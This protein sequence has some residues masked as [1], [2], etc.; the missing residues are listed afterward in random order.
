[1][2]IIFYSAIVEELFVNKE[3]TIEKICSTFIEESERLYHSDIKTNMTMGDIGAAHIVEKHISL[4]SKKS[5]GLNVL[6]ICNTG[7]LATCGYGTA[8]GV[9]RSLHKLNAL[10][11]VYCLETRPYN[12]GGRLTAYELLHDHIPCCLIA[13]SMV[14]FLASKTSIDVILVGGDRVAMNGDTIN[15]IGTLQL[16][17]VARHFGIPVYTVVPTSTLDP[18]RA[19]GRDVVIE[20]R[21]ASEILT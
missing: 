7:S 4:N 1:M 11:K 19:H 3:C 14:S 12:Q 16:A 17:I 13:D 15:K 6:T 20:E 18:G 21:S 5:R 9:I 8:L 2:F 10:E